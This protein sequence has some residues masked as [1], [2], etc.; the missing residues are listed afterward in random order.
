MPVQRLGRPARR[1]CQGNPSSSGW[2]TRPPVGRRPHHRAAVGRPVGRV[3]VACPTR[4]RAD[5]SSTEVRE[6]VTDAADVSSTTESMGLEVVDLPV[7]VPGEGQVRIAVVA[8]GMCGTDLHIMDGTY[9]SAP[10]VTLGHEMAGVARRRPGGRRV[11][12]RGAGLR[13]ARDQLRVVPVVPH[14]SAHALPGEAV[15]GYETGRRLRADLVVPAPQPARPA[16]LGVRLCGR[17]GRAAGVRGQRA[18][19]PRRSHPRGPGSSSSAP[20]PS[21]SSPPRSPPPPEPGSPW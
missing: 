17:A 9:A 18:H 8:A 10:P 5:S 12:G 6:L 2:S 7:P 11:L 19:R 21:G 1:W 4:S 14:R 16:D 20:A 13:R 3:G 15:R